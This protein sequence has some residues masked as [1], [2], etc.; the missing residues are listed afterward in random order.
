VLL[1]GAGSLWTNSGIV[2]IGYGS[3]NSL[4]VANG[5]T[6]AASGI[7]IA[8]SV[9]SSGTLNIGRF[10]GSDTAGTIITEGI[11]FGSG[12]GTI[13]FNQ[14]DATIIAAAISGEGTLNQLGTG[15]TTLSG[16]N[17]F[18][19][20]VSVDAGTLRLD[21]PSGS[22]AGSVDSISVSSGATLLISR[23]DQVNNL[24]EITLS[25]GTVKTA[26]GVS[27]AFGVLN[28]TTPS[29]LDFGA[30]YGNASSMSFGTYAPSYLLTINN[31]NFG[32]TLI[33]GSDLT[34]TIN[35]SSFFTFNSGGI[36]SY[37]WDQGSST[38]TITAI[39]ETSTV[40]AVLGLLALC[41]APLLRRKRAN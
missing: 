15:T 33:F 37:A 11:A 20:P 26:A 1:T 18:A 24:A 36:A 30:T 29:F 9:G 19:G 31:F 39:P 17:T 28:L 7:D 10:G 2:S 4:T 38:F 5:G 22:A 6:V 27:E 21:S 25:G 35:T 16:S 14:S 23:N 13:N 32:S 3:S 12:T 34:T 41:T 40:V 8:P